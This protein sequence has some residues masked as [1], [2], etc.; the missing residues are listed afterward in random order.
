MLRWK[1]GGDAVQAPDPGHDDDLTLARRILG[2]D[3]EAFDAFYERAFQ[4]VFA[5]ATRRCRE[6]R[7]AE[8][9]TEEVLAA[10]VATIDRYAGGTPLLVWLCGVAHRVALRRRCAPDR[11]RSIGL[12]T[13]S[14]SIPRGDGRHC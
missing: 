14:A 13:G 7:E 1:A 4:S 10:A 12:G 11:G 2:A 8:L 5:F 9:L 6:A 3:R